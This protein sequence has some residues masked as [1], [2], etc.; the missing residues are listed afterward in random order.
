MDPS[1]ISQHSVLLRV[2]TKDNNF[3]TCCELFRSSYGDY[4]KGK[5]N[6]AKEK[7]EPFGDHAKGK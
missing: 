6:Y 5:C 4:T 2:A 7:C 3:E 1:S